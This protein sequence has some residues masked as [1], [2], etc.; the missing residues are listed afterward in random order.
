MKTKI[1]RNSS[2][3]ILES[4][5]EVLDMYI[6]L[7]FY[8]DKVYTSLED[9]EGEDQVGADILTYK[10]YRNFAESNFRAIN[11]EEDTTEID[12]MKLEM[13]SAY[14]EIQRMKEI[15]KELSNINSRL[16]DEHEYKHKRSL[17]I[18]GH[19]DEY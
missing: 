15:I 8:V 19:Y 5:K 7:D 9:M 1:S 2:I 3:I 14:K 4:A 6:A 18:I 12:S 10:I 16:F 13:E 11:S 17:E